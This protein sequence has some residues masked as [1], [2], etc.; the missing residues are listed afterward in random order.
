[1]LK[2]PA[3]ILVTGLAAALFAACYLQAAFVICLDACAAAACVCAVFLRGRGAP[4]FAVIWMT[5]GILL[6]SAA[7]YLTDAISYRPAARFDGKSGILTCT[8]AEYPNVYEKYTAVAVHGEKL[9]DNSL[10]KSGILLYLDGRWAELEPGDVLTVSVSLSVPESRWNFDKFRY[11]RARRIYLTADAGEAPTVTAGEVGLR[12]VPAR[13]AGACIAR[14]RELMPERNAAV[15]AALIFGDERA[16][17]EEYAADLRS[18]GLSHI[19]AVS[20]MNVSFLVGLLLLLFR[21]KAG[22]CI[23]VPAVIL[24]VLMTGGSAS[25][26]RA[27]IMQLLWL[28]AY[29][30]N[31]ETD[32]A[33]SLFASC[34]L[35]LLANPFAIADVGLWLSFA[36]S[37]GLILLG[38]PLQHFLISRIPIRSRALRRIPETL[39]GVLCATLAAQVFVIPIQV[40]VFGEISLIAPLSNLLIVPA[41]EYAFT[42][43]AAALLLS[44]LWLPLGK[45]AAFLPKLLTDLQLAAVP[46]L[47]KLPLASVSAENAY[48]ALFLTFCYALALLCLYRRPKSP[49]L[50]AFCAA[51]ALCAAVFCSVL[52]GLMFSRL[53]IVDTAGGQSTI[54]CDR[55]ANVVV[56]CGGGYRSACTPV[57]DELR[58]SGARSVTLFILTDYR[59]ASAGNAETLLESVK[60]DAVLLPHAA[61]ASAAERRGEIAEAARRAGTK[62][63]EPDAAAQYAYGNVCV[64]ILE[65]REPGGD[66]G[67]LSAYLEVSG[68]CVLCL[69]SMYPENIACLLAE[70][71]IGRLHVVAAGDHYAARMVPPAVLH[72]APELCVFSS[73][74]G[75]DRDVLSRVLAGG[76]SVLDLERMGFVRIRLPRLYGMAKYHA[77]NA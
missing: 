6:G 13:L 4:A 14:L 26:L 16:L 31:R 3:I 33:N 38:S 5:C 57:L 29:F 39:A 41:A 37:L 72:R 52:D 76:S 77:F 68:C 43:G 61:D 36:A 22:S 46:A 30:L 1:M 48:L 58:R 32:P 27:G 42:F 63:L 21:R 65:N 60:V 12:Y 7:W 20:G 50:P 73:Y 15:L 17:P 74:A 69:G 62:I 44:F 23:A 9:N 71:G 18:A 70:A 10:R 47:A 24:F 34:G 59:T 45:A 35:I 40:L 64:R 28:A 53:S 55:D 19:T 25:V 11:Y 51:L 2:R 54:V 75:M 56:N 67:R 49:A 66:L 8:V